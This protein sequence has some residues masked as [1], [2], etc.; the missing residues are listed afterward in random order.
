MIDLYTA[1]TPNGYKV[2]IALEQLGLPYDLHAL[3]LGANEQREDWFLR[4]SPRIRRY[5]WSGTPYVADLEHLR[6]W[7][8]RMVARPA[9]ARGV[10]RPPSPRRT[11]VVDMARK[12]L[13][14]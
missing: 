14:R 12:M 13:V 3:D 5:D 9:C 6:A 11:E 8:D 4:I 1:A 7:M 2:S 10:T